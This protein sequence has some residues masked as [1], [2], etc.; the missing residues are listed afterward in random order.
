LPDALT[1]TDVQFQIVYESPSTLRFYG[2]DSENEIIGRHVADHVHPDYRSK[3]LSLLEVLKAEGEVRN[4]ELALLRRDGCM[5]CSEVS[6]SSIKD[7]RGKVVGYLGLARD[8]SD[9]KRADEEG[10]AS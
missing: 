10:P 2:Y 9:R 4:Q 6:A 1:L 7:D 8:V 5:V 3:A